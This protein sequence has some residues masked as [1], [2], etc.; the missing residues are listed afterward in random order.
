[1]AAMSGIM[2]GSLRKLW[3]YVEP[4]QEFSTLF[5]IQTGILIIAGGGLIFLLEFSKK[6]ND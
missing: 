5:H 3:P 2:I 6:T 4:T 1:M